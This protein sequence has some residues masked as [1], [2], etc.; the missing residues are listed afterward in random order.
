MRCFDWQPGCLKG[1]QAGWKE[2]GGGARGNNGGV[3]KVATRENGSE[4]VKPSSMGQA[5]RTVWGRRCL[6][7]VATARR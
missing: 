2:V 7:V 5:R 4:T 3:L 1:N 6:E